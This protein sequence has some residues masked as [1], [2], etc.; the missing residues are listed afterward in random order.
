MVPPKFRMLDF[1]HSFSDNGLTRKP[2]VTPCPSEQALS[3][4]HSRVVFAGFRW[5]ELSAGGSRSL[6]PS[7]NYSSRS[8]FF[9]HLLVLLLPVPVPGT[10]RRGHCAHRS[11]GRGLKAYVK[12]IQRAF[13]HRLF[14]VGHKVCHRQHA[15]LAVLA[16]Q[17]HGNRAVFHFLVAH[18]QHVRHLHQLRLANFGVHP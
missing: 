14:Y 8:T 2:L 7:T 1:R 5:K 17:P 6:S 16:P 4:L 10:A 13:C 12:L 3:R 9:L 11:R 18:N 15:Q